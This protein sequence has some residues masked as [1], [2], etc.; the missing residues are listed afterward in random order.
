METRFLEDEIKYT[1]K[2]LSSHWIY[3]N[4]N[5]LGDAAVAFIGE[6][7]VKLGEMVDI[8]DVI[9]KEPI[10]SSKMLNII[11]EH[12]SIPLIEGVF[13][14]RLIVT[15]LKELLEKKCPNTIFTRDGDDIFADNKKLTVS[16]ATKSL[17]SVLIHFGINIDPKGAPIAASGLK[18]DLN[19]QN[20]K[21]IAKE[22]L[23]NYNKEIN[24]IKNA[25]CKVRGVI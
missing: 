14:Q 4:F 22:L 3:R 23:D 16:I 1:G 5:I 18:T 9:N 20:I 21:E 19:I 24:S 6:C 11:I 17:T 8:E 2:E 15:I 13:R 25:V 7:E 10:Y 12:F